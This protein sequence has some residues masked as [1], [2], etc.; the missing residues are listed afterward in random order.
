MQPIRWAGCALADKG[1]AGREFQAFVVSPTEPLRMHLS[2]DCTML[3]IRIERTA[4]EALLSDLLQTRLSAPL[5]FEL[6]MDISRGAGG[7]WWENLIWATRAFDRLGGLTV[8]G[9]F[10][11]TAEAELITKLLLVQRSN[12]TDALRRKARAAP[13]PAVRQVAELIQVSPEKPHTVSS[14][15]RRAGVSVRA[16]QTA[17]QQEVGSDVVDYLRAV[18]L[19]RAHDELRS[20]VPGVTS[21]AEVARRWGFTNSGRFAAWYRERF[22][23]S[24]EGTLNRDREGH[25][26]GSGS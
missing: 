17:F 13:H 7:L 11:K 19:R 22:G 8:N 4:V 16:L 26:V 15:A 23:E 21:V 2:S 14:L 24:P 3:I 6:G 10:I 20:H 5:R 12:Y 18:R 1:F 9:A 25:S